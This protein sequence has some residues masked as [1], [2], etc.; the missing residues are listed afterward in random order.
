[1]NHAA[2]WFYVSHSWAVNCYLKCELRSLNSMVT[3][4]AWFSFGQDK[5][6]KNMFSFQKYLAFSFILTSFLD[7]SNNEV[8]KYMF[9][10]KNP[11]M[12]INSKGTNTFNISAGCACYGTFW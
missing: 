12:V 10:R 3:W 7:F 9:S 2:E 5:V 11:Q 1:M 8:T 6:P 4:Y